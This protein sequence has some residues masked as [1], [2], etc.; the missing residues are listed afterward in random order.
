MSAADRLDIPA[1]EICLFLSLFQQQLEAGAGP[2]LLPLSESLC[3]PASLVV[4]H[5]TLC[6][7]CHHFFL[8]LSC[9][10]Y[11]ISFALCALQR[12]SAVERC[13]VCWLGATGYSCCLVRRWTDV[14]HHILEEVLASSGSFFFFITVEECWRQFVTCS[15]SKPPPYRWA[16][17]G[18][19]CRRAVCVWLSSLLCPALKQSCLDS[20]KHSCPAVES[21]TSN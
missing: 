19:W 3:L 2:Y 12:C 10:S 17:N 11:C 9:L 14:C 16:A 18:A 5:L 21:K 15:W 6:V 20:G 7:Y 1:A 8:S 4:S 13:W